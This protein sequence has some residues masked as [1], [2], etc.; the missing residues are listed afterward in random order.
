DVHA[1]AAGGV[2]Q[3]EDG[4][5]V[6][7]VRLALAAPLVLPAHGQAAVRRGDARRRVGG[8]VPGGHLG[9][10]H[11]EAHAV[12]RGG[13]AGEVP[14]DEL[15]GQPER[16]EHLGAAVGGHRGDAHLAHH[17][18]HALAERAD[19]VAH[20]LLGGDAGDGAGV[21]ELLGALH[22]EVGVDGG[23]TVPDEE[24]DVVDLADVPGLDEEAD[25]GAGAPAQRVVVDGR[26]E[27]QR[28]DRRQGGG[29]VAVGQDDEA[30]PVL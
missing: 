13:G 8:G 28:G 19:D 11:V 29:G 2:L 18:E 14:V 20:R 3:P 15:T 9:G 27:E 26:G 7:E 12:E 16:L 22:G 17:L 6:E 10:E 25:L 24:G 1:A 21:D 5:R 23:R 30:H 4:L